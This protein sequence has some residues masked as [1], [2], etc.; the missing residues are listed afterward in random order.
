RRRGG[1]GLLPG[2]GRQQALRAHRGDEEPDRRAAREPR[3]EGARR[4]QPAPPRFCGAGQGS[5][6]RRPERGGGAA[7]QGRPEREA[8]AGHPG[9]RRGHPGAGSREAAEEDR[10][11][12]EEARA[13]AEVSTL[14][15]ALDPLYRNYLRRLDEMAARIGGEALPVRCAFADPP[16]AEDATA[17]A[18]LLRSWAVLAAQGGFATLG[19]PRGTAGAERWSGRLHG[20]AVRSQGAEVIAVFDLGTCPPAAID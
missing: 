12:G 14:A 16:A 2:Q 1:R 5:A 8:G 11:A 13:T 18:E 17:L 20:A 3:A 9:G 7:G 6:G 10:R 19:A 15:E 4:H